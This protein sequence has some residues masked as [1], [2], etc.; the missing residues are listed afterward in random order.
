MIHPVI[1][2]RTRSSNGRVGC[3]YGCVYGSV[4]W[5]A[6]PRGLRPLRPNGLARPYWLRVWLRAARPRAEHTGAGADNGITKMW[7]RR[8]MS[9]G[10]DYD[11]SHYLHPH[12]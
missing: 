7:N 10:S 1:F 9:A 6:V 8:N 5:V 3:E 12:P 4:Y 2:T 11:R